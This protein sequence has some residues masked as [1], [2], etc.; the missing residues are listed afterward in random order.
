MKTKHKTT[1]ANRR[2]SLKSACMMA[3]ASQFSLGRNHW[4]RG[5]GS[6]NHDQVW[7]R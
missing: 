5:P 4:K 1:L 2:E 3:L 6:I 7:A